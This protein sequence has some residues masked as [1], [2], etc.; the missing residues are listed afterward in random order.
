[1]Q[2]ILFFSPLSTDLQFKPCLGEL[3]EAA[4]KKLDFSIRE[5]D[6]ALL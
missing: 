2:R 3:E 4:K 5:D 1:M 6:L